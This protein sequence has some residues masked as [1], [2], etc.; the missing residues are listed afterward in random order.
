M[1]IWDGDG[2]FS[3]VEGRAGFRGGLQWD[4]CKNIQTGGSILTEM[5]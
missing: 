5:F 4:K 2:N 3:R 1:M